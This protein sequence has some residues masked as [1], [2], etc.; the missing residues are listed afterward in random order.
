[1]AAT[2]PF[3]AGGDF[4]ADFTPT[5][6]DATAAVNAAGDAAFAWFLGV[7]L[8]TITSTR[9]GFTQAAAS[10]DGPPQTLLQYNLSTGAGT[11]N[12]GCT[13]APP[14]VALGFV[15]TYKAA[16]GGGGGP[17]TYNLSSDIYL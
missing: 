6:L 7:P 17:T 8:A 1:M 15:V 16:A 12:A 5:E 9:S 2:T 3:T 14:S 11:A 13:A 4:P 10:T